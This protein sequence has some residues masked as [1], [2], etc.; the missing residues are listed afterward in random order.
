V[1]LQWGSEQLGV[2]LGLAFQ[3]AFQLA[4]RFAFGSLRIEFE[5]LIVVV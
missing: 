4:F 2:V 5:E 3:L 1:E